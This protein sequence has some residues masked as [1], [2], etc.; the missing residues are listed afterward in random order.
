MRYFNSVIKLNIKF[1]R[2]INSDRVRKLGT[3]TLLICLGTGKNVKS[4]KPTYPEHRDTAATTV[5]GEIRRAA[6]VPR[7]EIA[8][9]TG[10]SRATVTSVTADLIARGLIRETQNDPFQPGAKR[11]RPKV[12]L[13][14]HGDSHL[15]AGIE[16]A[17]RT[18]SV[19]IM[20]LSGRIL[21]NFTTPAPLQAISATDAVNNLKQSLQQALKQASLDAGDISGIGIS[22]AGFVTTPT[23]HVVWSPTLTERDIPFQSMLE[24]SLG[25]PVFVEND[26]NLVALAEQRIGLGR[27]VRNFVVISVEEGVGMGIVIDGKLYR[28]TNGSSAEFGH[29]KVHLDGALCRCGQRGCL[30]AYVGDFALLREARTT[31]DA[32]ANAPRSQQMA[33]LLAQAKAG[34]P[35]ATSIFKRSG[36]MFAMGL[37]NVVSLFSPE[38]IILCGE[39]MYYDFLYENGVVDEMEKSIFQVGLPLPEVKVH[40]WDGNMWSIGAAARAVDGVVD[41]VLNNQGSEHAV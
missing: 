9:A 25:I 13:Q 3:L 6:P 37:A 16:L 34:N 8:A 20:D 29:T 36:R 27:N 35:L 14:V 5:F 24:K 19:T 21:S 10:L 15:V 33:T 18:S 31:L 40:K 2:K 7:I 38:L 22:I 1:T 41:I 4:A 12:N 32:V 17:S 11:G 26:A 39:R 28:G 23:G 30:E